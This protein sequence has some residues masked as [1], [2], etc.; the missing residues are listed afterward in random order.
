VILK[1]RDVVWVLFSLSNMK[2]AVAGPEHAWGR[3]LAGVQ[4]VEE[5]ISPTPFWS[6]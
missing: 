1:Q 3:E 6:T 5:S 2:L 4:C